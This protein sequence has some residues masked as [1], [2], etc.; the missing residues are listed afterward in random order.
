MI[1]TVFPVAA[2]LKL[3]LSIKLPAKACFSGIAS[4]VP[5]VALLPEVRLLPDAIPGRTSSLVSMH[6]VG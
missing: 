6:Q 4:P 3:R 2:L 5:L 1:I